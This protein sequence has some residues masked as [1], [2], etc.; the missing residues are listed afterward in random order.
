MTNSLISSSEQNVQDIYEVLIK[1]VH[2]LGDI[3]IEEKKTSIHVKARSAFLGIHPKKKFLD[4]NIVTAN[5]IDAPRVKKT[6]QVSANRFHNEVRLEN[7]DQ[8]DTELMAWIQ[9]AYQ[10]LS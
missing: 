6:E 9:Q 1:K 10:L 4:I 5:P 8:I 3:T 7:V 2:A